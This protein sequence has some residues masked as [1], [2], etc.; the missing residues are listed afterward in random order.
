MEDKDIADRVLALENAFF[1]L[2][3]TLISRGALTAE[4]VKA[5]FEN[6]VIQK[7]LELI[8]P[9]TGDIKKI[10]ATYEKFSKNLI[11]GLAKK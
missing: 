10:F 8:S 1:V 5:A 6:D 9:D 11:N 3:D 2:V 7:R 4:V